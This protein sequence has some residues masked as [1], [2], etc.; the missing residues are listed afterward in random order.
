MFTRPLLFCQ[1]CLKGKHFLARKVKPNNILIILALHYICDIRQYHPISFIQNI[2]V[3]NL[4]RVTSL[5]VKHTYHL[6]PNFQVEIYIALA[7]DILQI[8]CKIA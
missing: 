1:F 4:T 5:R 7:V 2:L 8:S 6:G 3:Q